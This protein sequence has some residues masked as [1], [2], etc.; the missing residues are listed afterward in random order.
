MCEITMK[1]FPILVGLSW[2]TVQ[3]PEKLADPCKKLCARDGPSVCTHGS[4]LSTK[5]F[6]LNYYFRTASRTEHCYTL[7]PVP[8]CSTEYP[9]RGNSAA[10]RIQVLRYNARMVSNTPDKIDEE[11]SEEYIL[12]GFP[13]VD[14][15]SPRLRKTMTDSQESA[16]DVSLTLVSADLRY[17]NENE[18]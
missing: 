3:G 7:S 8:S 18:Q 14:I 13:F 1:I 16:T 12:T 6:C 5:G 10:R 15:S 11:P 9:M 17:A 4:V 2:S